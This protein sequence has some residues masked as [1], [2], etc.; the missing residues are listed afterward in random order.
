[1]STNVGSIH[2]DL[3]LNTK[4]FDSAVAGIKS[5]TQNIGNGLK[6]LGQTM[7]ASVTLPVVAGFGF[8]VKSASDLNETINKVEVAFKD[9][10]DVVKK[11]SKTSVQSMGLAE[12]S[13][14]DATALF[15]DMSTSMGLNTKQASTMSMGLT[16]LGADLAS[17]KN[18][19]FDRAQIAL[20]GV[21]TGETE[22]LKGLG[23]VMTEANLA[24]FAQKKGI[25]KNIQTM[26][27][28]EKVSLRYAY[29]MSVTKNAQGDFARTSSGTA[30]LLRSTTE[31]FKDLS[32][33]L[34]QMFLPAVNAV[35]KK[36]QSL[37][38][39]F[40]ALSKPQ[41]KMILLVVGI[42]AAIGPL[43]MILGMLATSIAALMSPIGIA[44]VAI[45]G[46][47]AVLT[48]L[49]LK[50]NALEPV[51][52]ALKKII[53][54]LKPSVVALWNTIATQLIPQLK[55]LWDTVK[56]V[57]IPVLK[58][59]GVLLAVTLVGQMYIFLNVLRI[60]IRVVSMVVSAISTFVWWVKLAVSA[61]SKAA[62]SIY[63][64]VKSIGS[65]IKSVFS[66]AGSWL[67]DAGKN[68]IQGLIN[69]IK[70]MFSSAT[71]IAGDIA[72][73]IKSKFTGILGINSP[74]RVFYE[75]GQN[76]S[77]GLSDGISRSRSTVSNAVEGLSTASS[78]Q[79]TPS[80]LNANTSIYGNI[81]IGS[82]SDADYFLTRL[83]RNQ[84]LASKN[85]ATRVG[86]VG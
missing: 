74:S 54:F 17:F 47:V 45:A 3:S 16:Q 66:N 7:T 73:G 69:G 36:I 26:T 71:N 49:H 51:I 27:Q 2:Y 64:S 70:D 48:Y 53:D 58:I 4:P 37:V 81:S 23:I 34:G 52:S 68:V 12:Q 13:A 10:A 22:A 62:S 43:L 60:I 85:I 38:E 14:L 59:L 5:K 33:K 9:Q 29:V 6:S 57:L 46:L 18:I 61:V 32:A 78:P 44:L 83:S 56:P 76:I 30:N 11:W 63:N 35:L 65:K 79:K 55:R 20:A 84:E 86:A 67:Y 80:Q 8:M 75:Y 1:M 25:T 28:A 42:V 31:R 77:K 21:Y 19:S 24:A 82:Q 41:Q 50:F 15:G 72:N 39:K 40:T